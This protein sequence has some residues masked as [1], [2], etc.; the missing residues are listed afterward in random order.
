MSKAIPAIQTTHRS[1]IYRSQLEARWAY[2]FDAFGWKYE[3]EPFPLNGYIPDFVLPGVINVMVE[4]KPYFDLKQFVPAIEKWQQAIEGTEYEGAYLL[5]VGAT[6][7][8]EF[9]GRIGWIGKDIWRR[10]HA[11]GAG[12]GTAALVAY[13]PPYDR[14]DGLTP[15]FL[16]GAYFDHD[17][18]FGAAAQ[19]YWNTDKIWAEAGN[20][21]RWRP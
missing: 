1:R 7:D 15:C 21:V 2:M 3:Y 16:S 12:E 20:A 11:L 6:L 4:V 19:S 10:A 5:V 8:G 9:G 17:T 18:Y 14:L 13:M